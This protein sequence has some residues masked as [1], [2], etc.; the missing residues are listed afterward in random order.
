MRALILAAALAVAGLAPASEPFL[1]HRSSL[2]APE[3]MAHLQT[4]IQDAGY[5]LRFVQPVDHGLKSRGVD[6]GLY[7]VVLFDPPEVARILDAHPELAPLLPLRITVYE[8]DRGIVLSSLRPTLL[9]PSDD[10]AVEALLRRWEQDIRE[11]L[12]EVG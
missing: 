9:T 5:Q 12:Q 8:D 10:P 4:A 3:T 11:I 1:Q 2:F 7:R 6:V